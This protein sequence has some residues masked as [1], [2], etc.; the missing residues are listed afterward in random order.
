MS[1]ALPLPRADIAIDPRHEPERQ[2]ETA[3]A[4]HQIRQ[5][6]LPLTEA[7]FI[8]LRAADYSPEKI[9]RCTRMPDRTVNRRLACARRRPGAVRRSEAK[10]G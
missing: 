5:A 2:V 4:A 8:G 7:R 3:A 6:G 9:A 10:V 1:A